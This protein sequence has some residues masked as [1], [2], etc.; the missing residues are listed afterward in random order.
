MKQP[1]GSYIS[2]FSHV[3][4]LSKDTLRAIRPMSQEDLHIGSYDSDSTSDLSQ[5]QLQL[6]WSTKQFKNEVGNA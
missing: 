5:K 6:K 2:A 1:Y 3:F 4:L